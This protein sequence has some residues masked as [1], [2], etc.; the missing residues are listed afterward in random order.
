M[1]SRKEEST[2]Y[3]NESELVL[4]CPMTYTYTL[5]GKRWKPIILWKLHEGSRLVSDLLREIPL[6]S[7]KMLYQDLIELHQHELINVEGEGVGKVHTLSPTGQSL[8]PLLQAMQTWGETHR[9]K[10]V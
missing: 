8:I 4:A 7:R 10:T 6:I 1:Y 2:N 9:P 3:Q 5:L